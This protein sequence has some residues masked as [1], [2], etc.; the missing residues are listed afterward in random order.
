MQQTILKELAFPLFRRA[1]TAIGSTAVTAG[2]IADVAPVASAVT[3]LLGL[4][5]D[6]GWSHIDRRLKK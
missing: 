1:G 2:L 6:L 5:W 4:C 3:L